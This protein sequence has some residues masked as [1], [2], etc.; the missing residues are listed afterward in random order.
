MGE[1]GR[2]TILNLVV[3]KGKFRAFVG[4]EQLPIQR[5]DH[6]SIIQ[7]NHTSNHISWLPGTSKIP[8][9]LM[10]TLALG[11]KTPEL[12]E[13]E[14]EKWRNPHAAGEMI[15]PNCEW[16]LVSTRHSLLHQ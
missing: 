4:D 9:P 12:K 6:R 13:M 10:P 2:F 1:G 15:S 11:N 7:V 14:L 5:E 8:T 3:S 16:Y